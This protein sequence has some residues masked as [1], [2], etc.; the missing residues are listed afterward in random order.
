[1]LHGLKLAITG[2]NEKDILQSDESI[3][4]A[5]QVVTDLQKWFPQLQAAVEETEKT[6]NSISYNM[7]TVASTAQ[8]IYGETNTMQIVL[9]S[10]QA[11]SAKV[12]S[13]HYGELAEERAKASADLREFNECIRS[14]RS[15]HVEC[16]QTLK[17]KVY[18]QGKVDVMR[19]KD[20]EKSAKRG[21]N[22]KDAEKRLRNEQKLNE[23]TGELRFNCDKL[24]RELETI[25]SRK[26]NVLA[27]VLKCYIHTQNYN[28]ARN[29][30]PAVIACM[31]C[32]SP[33]TVLG[34][35]LPG[36]APERSQCDSAHFDSSMLVPRLSFD[37]PPRA[38]SPTIEHRSHQQ[39]PLSHRC[40]A[41]VRDEPPYTHYYPQASRQVSLPVGSPYE[42]SAAGTSQNMQYGTPLSMPGYDYLADQVSRAPSAMLAEPI[43]AEAI[44]ARPPPPALY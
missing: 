36:F 27:A 39:Q 33:N 44:S 42:D 13:V 6:W 7:K 3:A 10:L 17:N 34:G 16:V 2:R 32:T 35:R 28:F 8:E 37:Q 22:D 38:P 5:N 23:M 11:A 43:A 40:S 31:P 18:Y 29:P 1:M 25:V 26:E 21:K 20:A 41:P 30:M 12:A 15:L 4:Y 9:E 24:S 19:K 14:L